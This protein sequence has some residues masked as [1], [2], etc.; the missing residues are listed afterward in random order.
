MQNVCD[1]Q[2][3]MSTWLGWKRAHGWVCLW[4]YFRKW[5]A[6]G[7]ACWVGRSEL[8]W[9]APCNEGALGWRRVGGGSSCTWASMD[10]SHW[11]VHVSYL[12]QPWPRSV[13]GTSPCPRPPSPTL[14]CF[15]GVSW[16]ETSSFQ[17]WAPPVSGLLSLQLWDYSASDHVSQC[18]KS[19]LVFIQLILLLWKQWPIPYYKS[20]FP[21]KITA[22]K[23]LIPHM[24]CVKNITKLKYMHFKSP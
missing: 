8:T 24:Y 3:W 15:S 9:A 18:S 6:S 4:G 22:Y 23:F 5:L 13:T 21:L 2:S 12:L 17:D 10:S 19:V 16:S 14:G 1:D 11:P 7:P 20:S